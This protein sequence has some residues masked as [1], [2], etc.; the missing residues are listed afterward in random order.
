MENLSLKNEM[1]KRLDF[2]K[3][4]C[5][6]H[7]L[8]VTNQRLEIFK[9]VAQ[10]CAHPSAEK[11]FESVRKKLPNVSLDTVYRTLASL[12]EMDLLFRVGMLNHAR[13][14]ADLR[15]HYHFVCM[16][17]G[18]VYDIF[19]EENGEILFPRLENLGTVKNISL[20]F[21]GIC[22]NCKSAKK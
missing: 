21:R 16:Q 13:F 17:C 2:F 15:P 5:R 22:K 4:E 14:D 11:V 10:S 18:E 20:Q 1:E 9:T 3:Q 7:H 6:K 12:E 19:P 8:R